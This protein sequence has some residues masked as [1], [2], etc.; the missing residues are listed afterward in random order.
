MKSSKNASKKTNRKTKVVIAMSG[1]VDSSVAA[2]FMKEKGYEVTAAFLKCW[3]ATKTFSGE[4]QWKSERRF[5][6]KICNRLDIPLKT[7]DAEKEYKKFVIDEMFKDYKKGI[8]PNPDVL[9]NET[10]K[11]PFLLKEAKKFNADYVV[12][13]H[14]AQIKK[15]QGKYYMYRAKDETKDQ[16]YFLYRLRENDLKKILFPIG[17]YT[18]EQVRKIAKEN[19]F[20]NHEKK[21]TVGICFIGK[22]NMKDFLKTKIK[23]KKGNILDTDGKI[24]GTHD[25]VYYYTI[26]Q[27]LRPK[28]GLKIPKTT[29][30]P[31][32]MS[33]WYVAKKD[34]KKNLL[35]VAPEG[36]KDL[37]KNTL[38]ILNFHL[39]TDSIQEFKKEITKKPKKVHAR[40][41]HV[42]E[43]IPA[44]IS[45]DSK[46]KK[47][48]LKLQ[49][50][51]TGVSDG[52]AVILYVGKK[53]LGG[54]VISE[55][56]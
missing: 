39:I 26:G 25:G 44:I 34:I 41:R 47:I 32:K 10:V 24:I 6:Q 9:C 31:K 35:I 8:T 2:L 49:K 7:I 3:S 55:S 17:N 13:G 5:A 30:D 50:K 4:C 28:I 33:K 42:G 56:R 48:H 53:V 12:T 43:L 15:S 38:T 27:R 37:E 22:T 29:D 19:G 18:K 51:L 36:N 52:Q 11:F 16:S 45:H 1:G 46:T 40:I 54:G 14:F 23:P 20:I 21:S